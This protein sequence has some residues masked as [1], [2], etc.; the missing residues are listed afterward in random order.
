[1]NPV[2]ADPDA[3]YRL[4]LDE[5]RRGGFERAAELMREALR[6]A[7]ERALF[8]CTLARIACQTGDYVRAAEAFNAAEQ[9]ASAD[10]S[11]RDHYDHGA[12]LAM[13]GQ[14]HQAEAAYRRALPTAPDWP[15]LLD[16]LAVSLHHL[17]RLDEAEEV[18]H[19]ALAA[20]L[21]HERGFTLRN[22]ANLHSARDR[23]DEAIDCY[24]RALTL[25]PDDPQTHHDLAAIHYGRGNMEAAEHHYRRAYELAP[26][27]ADA[28]RH[29]SE[30]LVARERPDQAEPIY[31]ALLEQRPDDPEILNG[32]GT[33]LNSQQRLDQ[34]QE[35]L[36]RAVSAQPTNALYHFNL[37][38]IRERAEQIE[39]ALSAYRSA[40]E[41][42]PAM[43]EAH[44]C[45]AAGLY[46]LER[47]DEAR[48]AYQTVLDLDPDNQTA[49][50]LL[51]AIS[52]HSPAN[53]PVAYVTQV[54]DD[55]AERY[56]QHMTETLGYRAPTLICEL[57]RESTDIPDDGI[58]LLDLGCGTGMVAEQLRPYTRLAHGV[59][60]S[61]GMLVYARLRGCYQQLWSDELVAL[62][63]D[64]DRGLLDYDVI[65]AAD[66]L[67]YIGDLDRFMAG[68]H[69]RL[70]LTG[71]LVFTVEELSESDGYALRSTGRYAHSRSYVERTALRH[72]LTVH[73]VRRTQV[74]SERNQ[75]VYGL[76]WALRQ[77]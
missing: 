12:V 64:S 21:P 10:M 27:W 60:L 62:L 31:R 47:L 43:A 32:L 28:A 74:R 77:L 9:V 65:V 18:L 72:G 11:A 67:V 45:L 4:G 58:T 54:F 23:H 16:N 57:I 73:V 30:L 8:H 63:R 41:C 68:C 25:T 48:I 35:L 69:G 46:R 19:R 33:C 51:A 49:R 1:M 40:I 76:L 15:I 3:L 75:P 55:Y 29:L 39:P 2:S 52:G 66:V 44:S 71:T 14:H 61:P 42:D 59:D 6:T 22:L 34:A 50:H 38:V 17:Q 13:L 26:D 56:D 70:A 37:G 24:Q 7:P 5:A 53:A 20:H 36:E